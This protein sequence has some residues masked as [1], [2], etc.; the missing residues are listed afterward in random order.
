MK[1][2][3]VLF[4]LPNLHGGGAE[5]VTVNIM[6]QLDPKLFDIHLAIARYEGTY[7][8]LIPQMVTVHNLNVKKTV[9]AIFKLRNVVKD[10]SP[11]TVYSTLFN[12]NIVLIL[13][14]LGLRNKPK[15]VLRSPNSPKLTLD[16]NQ[17]N[18]VMKFLLE[19]A[20]KQADLILAQTPEMKNE[21]VQYHTID[22]GK[23]DVFLNPL[24][25]EFI[26]KKIENIKSPFD[27]NHINIVAAGR[28]TRQKGFDILLK[29]FKYINTE[30]NNF[31]L[32]IIGDDD[33]EEENIQKMIVDLSL[34][35]NV[36]LW[37]FQ[38]NPYQFFYFSDLFVLSSRWEGLPNAVLEN[39]YLKKPIVA[40]RCI[41]FMDALIQENL[42]GKLVDVENPVQLAEAILNYKSI[43]LN[44]SKAST[45]QNI[46]D[47]FLNV[48]V[49]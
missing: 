2:T 44:F 5:R 36:K 31:F 34:E 41:P 43:K 39:L 17:L 40:T 16:N 27:K 37:G 26:D 49:R 42:N 47:L 1:K 33:G 45:N 8:D 38:K 13:A 7:I 32:H 48:G 22:A 14:L 24:D 23:I 35:N 10:I 3:K 30:D 21:I 25:T 15:I 19:Y 11:D 46:N 12:A 20:Y 9:F 6:R 4:F 18:V 29:A 28:L